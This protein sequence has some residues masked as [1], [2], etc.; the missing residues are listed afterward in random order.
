[1]KTTKVIKV[2]YDGSY[3][4]L[5]SGKL[6]VVLDGREWEFPPY[7]LHS[8]GG[9]WFSD[10]YAE[11]YVEDGPWS[12]DEWPEGFPEEDKEAVVERINEEIPWGCCGGCV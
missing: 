6:V 2:N 4:N 10:D 8:G 7:C 12:I 1:M 11:V 9:V 5:C 3:P